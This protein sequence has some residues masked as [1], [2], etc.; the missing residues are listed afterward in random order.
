MNWYKRSILLAMSAAALVSRPSFATEP[1]GPAYLT[2]PGLF[3]GA[4]AGVPP[5][6]L[7][8][9]DQALTYQADIV[10]PVTKGIGNQT[11]LSEDAAV[12]GL[13]Y[14]PGWT[15]LGATYD[16]VVALPAA[17]RSFNDPIS[18]QAVGRFDTYFVPYELS[19]KFGDSGFF[20][21]TGTAFYAPTGSVSGPAGLGNF[22]TP[23]WVFQPE[24]IVSYLKDGWNLSAAIYD[25]IHTANSVTHYRTGDVLHADFT[26]TKTIGKWTFGPVGYYCGQITNDQSSAF[27]GNAL[28]TQR[29]DSIGVGGLLG[30]DFGSANLSVW[31]TQEVYANASGATVGAFDPSS[32]TRGFTALVNLSYRIWAPDET[33][34]PA[35]RPALFK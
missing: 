20:V 2:K 15:I 29:F 3:V 22:G 19:W 24:L 10:G 34:A 32:I 35:K 23:Y 12:M 1:G 21:K 26:A 27:Y 4:S 7:Y 28:G 11:R 25:E 16:A 6:G 33:P 9:F 14:V 30:Y 31:A 5:P 13:L 8:M 18:S 17:T